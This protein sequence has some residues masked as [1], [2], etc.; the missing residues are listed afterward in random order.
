MCSKT[1]GHVIC[2]RSR[3]IYVASASLVPNP[4]EQ[5]VDSTYHYESKDFLVLT[6]IGALA[7]V[8]RLL[9]LEGSCLLIS[10]E[11]SVLDSCLLS[12]SLTKYRTPG[13]A[14]VCDWS[15][16]TERISH[17]LIHS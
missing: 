4:Q 2:H 10:R 3:R 15:F 8:C 11:S 1:A 17:T 5:I 14:E 9:G 13:C 16:Q 6:A 12:A 7:I